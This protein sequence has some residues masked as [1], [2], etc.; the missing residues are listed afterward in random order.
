MLLPESDVTDIVDL[1]PE[2][3]QNYWHVL[4]RCPSP[5]PKRYQVIDICAHA[6]Q[7]KEYR[8]HRV[9]CQCGFTTAA[10][11]VGVV[12]A[13]PFGPGLMARVCALTGTY[14]LS[15]R[16]ALSLL[17]D[18]FNVTLS[19]GSI[20][21]IE[22]RVSAVLA[23]PVAHGDCSI[24]IERIRREC[25]SRSRNCRPGSVGILFAVPDTGGAESMSQWLLLSSPQ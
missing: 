9:A 24:H 19:V 14:K 25:L 4:P 11:V 3:C 8:R 18:F 16:D 13:S 7:V 17:R 6:L 22:R 2:V 21:S 23:K 5:A 12:P 10:T 20:S 1:Y 15:R